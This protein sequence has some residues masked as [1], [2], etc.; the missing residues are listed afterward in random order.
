MAVIAHF[1]IWIAQ[2]IRLVEYYTRLNKL[3]RW[4]LLK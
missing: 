4:H 3:P 2:S 1:Y